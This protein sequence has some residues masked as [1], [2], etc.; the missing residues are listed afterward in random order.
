MSQEETRASLYFALMQ[1]SL[2]LTLLYCMELIESQCA[3]SLGAF[4]DRIEKDSNTFSSN[5]N[6]IRGGG[7]GKA[8]KSLR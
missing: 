8:Q 3:A 6:N 1:Q 5:S 7:S 2:A 4:L